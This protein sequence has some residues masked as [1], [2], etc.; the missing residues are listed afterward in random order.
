MQIAEHL[1]TEYRETQEGE[2]CQVDGHQY[3]VVGRTTSFAERNV[4]CNSWR[5]IRCEFVDPR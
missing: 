4:R 2:A 3:R 1:Y 5:I